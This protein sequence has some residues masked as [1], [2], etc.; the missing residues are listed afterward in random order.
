MQNPIQK[1]KREKRDKRIRKLYPKLTMQKIADKEGISKSRV[2][3]ILK[4]EHKEKSN[5]NLGI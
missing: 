2:K 1:L 3:Q 4:A 5:I